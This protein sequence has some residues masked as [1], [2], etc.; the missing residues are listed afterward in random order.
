M[1]GVPLRTVQ[2]LMGHQD[3]KTTERYA[4]LSQDHLEEAAGKL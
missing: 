4:H 1:R 3:S 2:I